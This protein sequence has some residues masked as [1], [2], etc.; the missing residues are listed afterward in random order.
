VEEKGISFLGSFSF[1]LLTLVGAAKR[2]RKRKIMIPITL[3]VG[4][5]SAATDLE[6]EHCRSGPSKP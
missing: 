4:F 6:N 1:E 5:F 2:G 3:K